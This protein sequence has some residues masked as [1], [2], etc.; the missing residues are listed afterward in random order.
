MSPMCSIIVARAIGMI[1]MIALASNFIIVIGGRATIAF[2]PISA[3]E[4][5]P[6][7]IA[8]MY[9]DTTPRT[10]GM[11][12]SIPLPQMLN[13][14]VTTMATSATRQSALQLLIALGARLRPIAMMIGPVTTG[15]KKCMTFSDP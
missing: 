5:S 14:I 12:F 11:I 6:S 8:T 1:V 9:D 2:D 7:A 4:T 10:I 13:T 3:S 15:G